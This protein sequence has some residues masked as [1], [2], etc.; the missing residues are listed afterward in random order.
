MDDILK[1]KIRNEIIKRELAKRS[2]LLCLEHL[3]WPII[4]PNTPFVPSWFH[5]VLDD[6]LQA[7]FSR[8]IKR[9]VIN[10]QPRAGKSG[11]ISVS[12]PIWGWLKDA[13]LRYM[14]GSHNYGLSLKL[15]GDRLAV[16][17]SQ[18]YNSIRQPLGSILTDKK[19]EVFNANRGYF[20]VV[21]PKK[22]TGV[23]CNFL[24]ADDLT[25]WDD[26]QS[27]TIR[28]KVNLNFEPGL[29]SRLDDKEEDVAI[30]VTQRLH[31]HDLSAFVKDLGFE[32][33][34]LKTEETEDRRIHL[35]YSN[36]SIQRYKGQLLNPAR[37]GKEYVDRLK[38]SVTYF[39]VQHQQDTSGEIGEIFKIE[40][41]GEYS[42][43][44]QITQRIGSIDT[45]MTDNIG[46]SSRWAFSIFGSPEI[47]KTRSLDQPWYLMDCTAKEYRYKEGKQAL[48][49]YIFDN[50]L[51]DLLV[52]N[53]SSG[54]AL[55]SDLKDEFPRVKFHLITP[56][57]DKL[58]R[59]YLA[60]PYS[61]LV[62]LPKDENLAWFE[63]W[64]K[65]VL[66]FPN[67]QYDDRADTLTQFLRWLK[68]NDIN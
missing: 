36:K 7:C 68:F 62:L 66:N 3:V 55:E 27:N 65:E 28:E 37:E 17:D 4:E 50:D 12:F 34:V 42:I 45:A 33:L 6:Y 64:K 19:K 9:L 49:D 14:F 5:H 39:Q 48:R 15:G 63:E 16:V 29:L 57:K 51:T 52:E 59:A 32:Y 60:T 21:N 35:P 41:F 43:L 54:T 47:S 23:G 1:R 8:Q 56:I 31:G 40:Q 18:A 11:F 25:S 58:T 38:Q 13:S 53:K 20:F 22:A 26:A 46:V 10:I 44:P 61:D 24:I 2:P 67:E 30:L